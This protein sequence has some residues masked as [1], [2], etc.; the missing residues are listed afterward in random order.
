[1]PEQL[2]LS[3]FMSV[4]LFVFMVFNLLFN[5]DKEEKISQDDAGGRR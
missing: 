1:M 3:R 4:N 5:M 2:F